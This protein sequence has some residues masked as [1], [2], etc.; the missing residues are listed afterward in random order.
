MQNRLLLIL[1]VCLC[2]WKVPTVAAEG[3]P[4]DKVTTIGVIIPLTGG[5]S[6]W[7]E[8]IRQSLEL[9]QPQLQHKVEFIFEDEGNCE[10]V[11]GLTAAQSILAKGAK[12][13]IVGCVSTTQ[14]LLGEAKRKDLLLISAG[15]LIRKSYATEARVLNFAT[16]VGTE[17]KY[18]AEYIKKQGYMSVAIIRANESFGE[19]LGAVL[20]DNLKKLDIKVV[21]DDSDAYTTN[22]FKPAVLNIKRLKPDILI[23]NLDEAKQSALIKALT[24]AKVQ[25]PLLSSYGLESNIQDPNSIKYLEGVTYTYPVNI[26]EKSPEKL[27][28]DQ[29]FSARYNGSIPNANSYFVYDGMQIFDQALGSCSAEDTAC[30]HNFFTTRG[31]VVGISGQFKFNADGSNDRPYKI[32]RVVNGKF[33]WLDDLPVRN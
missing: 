32:K 28:F 1:L 13:L 26:S 14:A 33:T 8:K 30:L 23:I 15:L 22:D 18:L 24:E 9:G 20:T 5:W 10:V 2:S 16:Q 19:E 25:I 7:G 12:T 31:E 11:K 6:S 17:A 27:K 3:Q 4:A 29:D 21:F